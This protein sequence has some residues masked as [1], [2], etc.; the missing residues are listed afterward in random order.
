MGEKSFIRV[1]FAKKRL[2]EGLVQT[3]NQL[4]T[5]LIISFSVIEPS[6]WR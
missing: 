5:L 3:T 4:S 1:R 2:L 6:M